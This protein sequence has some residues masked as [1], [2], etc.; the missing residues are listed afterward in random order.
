M[1]YRDYHKKFAN[2]EAEEKLAGE[3]VSWLFPDSG[4]S[5]D[6]ADDASDSAAVSPPLAPRGVS[7]PPILDDTAV[8]VDRLQRLLP[9]YV[10]HV[11]ANNRKLCVAHLQKKKVD[12]FCLH[13]GK[14]LCIK[15]GCFQNFHSLK[16][17]LMDDPSLSHVEK[18]CNID[19]W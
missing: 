5:D 10:G 11:A 8:S 6:S 18:R 19:L 14:F 7:I 9:H 3:M 1:I 16:N 4:G 2:C 13:C 12:T 17:Y 15:D